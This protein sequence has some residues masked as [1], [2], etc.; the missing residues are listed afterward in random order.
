MDSKRAPSCTPFIVA[1]PLWSRAPSRDENGAP[2]ID[3]MMLIPGLKNADTV[4]IESYMV[5]IRNSLGDFEHV[6]AYVDLNIRLN[7]LWISSRAV[8]GISRLIMQAIQRE[9]P[10]A[11]I[12]A[13][14]FNPESFS[15]RKSSGWLVMLGRRV[16]K[17]LLLLTPGSTD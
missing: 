13:G 16:K 12:V 10:E 15:G 3:F 14:D 1:S 4:T 2:Y 11:K 5:K 8:P 17:R 6:V 9:I 7:I